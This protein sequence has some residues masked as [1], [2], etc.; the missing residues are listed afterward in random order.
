MDDLKERFRKMDKDWE[1]ESMKAREA[2]MKAQSLIVK[3]NNKLPSKWCW[4]YYTKTLQFQRAGK[5]KAKASEFRKMC[6]MV[7]RYM[8]E[9][10]VR[11]SYT[12][13]DEVQLSGYLHLKGSVLTIRIEQNNPKCE[14]ILETISQPASSYVKITPSAYCLGIK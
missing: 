13:G 7:E 9:K 6:R 2:L 10:V 14:M 5:E 12:I 3:V 4:R 8:K 11:T 1:E